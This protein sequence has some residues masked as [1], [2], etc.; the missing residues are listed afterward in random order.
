MEEGTGS[1]PPGWNGWQ[2]KIRFNA[3]HEP[4]TAPWVVIAS[5][6]YWEHE[7]WNRQQPL[8]PMGNNAFSGASRT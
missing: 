5:I 1:N 4:R 2:R 6:A 3:S 7:G 8:C